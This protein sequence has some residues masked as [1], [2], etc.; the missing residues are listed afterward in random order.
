LQRTY[1]LAVAIEEG[2]EIDELDEATRVTLF[3]GLREL[4]LNAA[5]H[6]N[7][8]QASLALRAENEHFFLEVRDAGV[9]FD[10]DSAGRGF[11][12]A[13]LRSRIEHL[14]GSMTI[15]SSRN[16]GTRVEIRVPL[17]LQAPEPRG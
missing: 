9:G 6:A 12:L 13:N 14:G 2:R 15:D 16:G 17:M 11:G 1:G 7:T 5:R 4:L 3:R 8:T 10:P